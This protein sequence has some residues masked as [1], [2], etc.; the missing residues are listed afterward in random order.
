M[1]ADYIMPRHITTQKMLADI[2][3]WAGRPDDLTRSEVIRIWRMWQ[4]LNQAGVEAGEFEW[5]MELVERKARKSQSEYL[6]DEREREV[7]RWGFASLN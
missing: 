4:A 7:E 5:M 3:Q 1:S 2:P 6:E